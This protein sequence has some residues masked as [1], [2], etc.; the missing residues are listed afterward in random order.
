[1]ALRLS[2]TLGLISGIALLGLGA[3]PARAALVD[4]TVTGVVTA[5]GTAVDPPFGPFVAGQAMSA[6]LT[7]DS[8]TPGP[9]VIGTSKSYPFAVVGGTYAIGSYV[10]SAITGSVGISD[11]DPSSNDRFRLRGTGLSSATIPPDHVPLF[12]EIRLE[13]ATQAVF[14]SLALPLALNLGDFTSAIWR[15]GFTPV[16]IGDFESTAFVEGTLST[17]EVTVREGPARVPG[18]A[19]LTALVLAAGSAL[20]RGARRRSERTR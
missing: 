17:L 19:A 7:Y 13:D 11:D 6:T 3:P 9:T 10:G 20:L 5:V 12:F 15:L 16:V 2:R 1:M 8:E 18:P 4:V 14:D